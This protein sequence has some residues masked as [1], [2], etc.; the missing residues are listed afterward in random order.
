MNFSPIS[1]KKYIHR[2]AQILKYCTL[3]KLFEYGIIISNNIGIIDY[4]IIIFL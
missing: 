4:F 1:N 3:T 2:S